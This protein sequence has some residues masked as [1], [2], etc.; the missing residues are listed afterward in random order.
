MNPGDLKGAGIIVSERKI[1]KAP[2]AGW[3]L[4]QTIWTTESDW[5]GR[6]KK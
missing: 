1:E 3:M 5:T 6:I 4:L 2:F